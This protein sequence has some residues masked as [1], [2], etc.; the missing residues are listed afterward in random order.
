[1]SYSQGHATGVDREVIKWLQDLELSFHPNNLRRDLSNGYLVAEIFSHYYPH[2]ISKYS[3]LNGVSF[4]SKQKNW[5]R[6]QK[7]LKKKNLELSKEAIY[8]CIHCEPGAAEA[9]LQDI[10]KMLTNQ[11][12]T[13]QNVTDVQGQQSQQSSQSRTTSSRSFGNNLVAAGIMAE[14]DVSLRRAQISRDGRQL[15]HTAAD[16]S[17]P[18]DSSI[19]KGAPVS[20]KEIKVNQPVRN[21]MVNLSRSLHHSVAALFGHFDSS[22]KKNKTV[23]VVHK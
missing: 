20:Y 13:T 14:S 22:N 15:E 4:S 11:K 3:F 2:D 21:S 16:E 17:L 7:F 18:T 1:M 8:G 23:H 9:L 12:L 19:W 5:S 6:I 10:Y